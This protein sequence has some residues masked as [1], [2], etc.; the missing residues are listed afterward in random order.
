MT[1][2]QPPFTPAIAERLSGRP[3]TVLLDVDGT[4]APIA[5][6]PE[7][8]VVPAI[9]RAIVGELAALP[10]TV[11]CIISGRAALDAAS[12]VGVPATWTIGNHGLEIGPPHEPPNPRENLERFGEAMRHALE[13]SRAFA[14]AYSGVMVEDKRWSLSVHYRLVDNAAVADVIRGARAIAERHGLRATSGRR[15]VEI[16]PPI[17]VDKGTAALDLLR[18]LGATGANASIFCAGD[19]RTD[20][21]MFRRVR[22]AIPRAVTVRVLGDPDLPDTHAEYESSAELSVADPDALR[23]MLSG[24]VALRCA[25]SP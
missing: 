3:F 16:R 2:L 1:A 17:D 23:E 13:E 12:V 10:D 11:V 6:R 22:M 21:D 5:R 25:L 14:A 24:I 19:D 4:L 18:D 7:E 20:E 9:T 8:A 15:I